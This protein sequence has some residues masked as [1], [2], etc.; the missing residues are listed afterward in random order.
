MMS[1]AKKMKNRIFAIPA[2][3]PAM[4][5]KPRSPAMTA[6]MRKVTVQ[7]NIVSVGYRFFEER[8]SV[9]AESMPSVPSPEGA[10]LEN[11]NGPLLIQAGA[12]PMRSFMGGNR[13]DAFCTSDLQIAIEATS[14]VGLCR[15]RSSRVTLGLFGCVFLHFRRELREWTRCFVALRLTCLGRVLRAYFYKRDI[16]EKR[17]EAARLLQPFSCKGIDTLKKTGNLGLL[18]SR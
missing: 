11:T 8:R 14:F 13:V 2:A 6:M 12:R 4:P 3:A 10:W 5:V 1:K 7:D 18:A 15:W 9:F 17:S 16:F